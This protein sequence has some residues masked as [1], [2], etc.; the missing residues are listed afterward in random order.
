MFCKN[1]DLRKLSS[2]IYNSIKSLTD[3]SNDVYYNL[4]EDLENLLRYKHSIEHFW[5][6]LN[7][8]LNLPDDSL[9]SLDRKKFEEDFR[10]C[11]KLKEKVNNF[12]LCYLNLI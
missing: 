4:N 10:D 11:S 7:N 1:Q 8:T 5:D 12:L 9:S 6:Y 2:L 3:S